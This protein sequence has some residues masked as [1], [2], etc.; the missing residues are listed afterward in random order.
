MLT[1]PFCYIFLTNFREANFNLKTE[2]EVFRD[3]FVLSPVYKIVAE[4]RTIAKYLICIFFRFWHFNWCFHRASRRNT[5]LHWIIY[6]FKIF[7]VIFF[8]SIYLQFR[9]IHLHNMFCFPVVVLLYEVIKYDWKEILTYW[10]YWKGFSIFSINWIFYI[11]NVI[12][13]KCLKIYVF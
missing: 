9:S 7:S 2:C 11:F 12:Y 1:P 4:N 6:Y 8:L 3:G 10:T 13:E 5:C